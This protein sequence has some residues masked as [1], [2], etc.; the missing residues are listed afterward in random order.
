M[1]KKTI[2]LALCFAMLISMLAAG[3]TTT[4]AAT[5]ESAPTGYSRIESADDFSWDNANVYFLL[6]DRFANGDTSNDHSYGRAL[7]ANGSPLSGWQTAPGT[8][9]GGDFKGLT[10]KINEGYFDDLGVNAIWLSA[11]YEQIHGYVDSGDGH[12]AHYSYHGYYVLDYTE[13]DKN[14]GT[15]AEFKTLVDTAHAHGIRVV[16]DIV[17]NHAGYNNIVDMEEFN[18][19]TITDKSA[20][21]AYKY[22]LTGVDGFHSFIDYESSASDWGRWWGNDW[23]RSGLPGYTGGNGGDDITRCLAGLPD[24]RTEST[25]SVSVPTFLQTK[26]QKEGTLSAKQSKYSGCTTVSDY[27]TTWLSEWVE[28][29]GVDGFR[30]DTAKHV[31]LASWKKLKT[32]CVTALQN[33]RRNNPTA[34]GAD[35]DEDFWMTGECWDYG[36]GKSEYHTV[37][38]FDSMINFSYSGRSLDGP[39]SIN[40]VYQD[41]ADRINSDPNFNVLTYNS[42]HDS[43]LA[44]GDLYW[45]GTSLML[46]PG[47]VQPFYGDETNRPTVPGMS[48]DGHGGSGHSLRS[49]MNWDS[50]DTD[51]LAHWQKVGKFRN[52]HVAVGAG[53]HRLISAYNGSTGYTFARTYDDGDVSDAVVCCIGAPANQNITVNLGSTFASGKTVTNEYDGTTA[54]VTNG[55]ATFNSGPQGV[56][57]ISGPQ[58]TINMSLKSEKR[59]FYD[60]MTVTVSLRGADYAMV[61]VA[62]G[63]PFRVVDGQSFEI[64][65]GIEVG[66]SFDVTMTATN[67]V[68]TSEMTFSYKKKDPSAVTYVYF[69]N[70]QYN[71]SNVN[72]YVYKGDGDSASSIKAWPGEAMEFDSTTGLYVYEVDED[73]AD[74]GAVVFNA[75]SG[76]A[77]YPAEGV[78]LEI[79]GTDKILINKTTWKEYENE[80]VTP[81]DPPEPG[82]MRTIYFDNS[83]DKFAVPSCHAWK[84]DGSGDIPYQTW[85]G[86]AMTSLGNNLYKCEVPAEYNCCL[87]VDRNNTEAKTTDLRD[88]PYLNAKYSGGSWTEV[89]GDETQPTDPT[90]PTNPT[91]PTQPTDPTEPDTGDKVLLGDANLDGNITIKDVTQIQRHCAELIALSGDNYTAADVDKSGKVAIKDATYVQMFLAEMDN[92]AYVNTYV[93]KGGNEPT[94]PTTPTNP[95]EPTT[96]SEDPAGTRTIYLDVTGYNTTTP[97]VYVWKKGSQD[98]VAAFPGEAMT[99]VSGSIYSYTCQADYNCCIFS[100]DGGGN[101]KITGDLEDIPYTKALYHDGWTQYDG[102]TP[103]NPTNPPSGDTVTL[104][105]GTFVAGDEDWYAWTW[106]GDS[107][108]KWLS[109]TGTATAY[110]FTGDIGDHIL[111]VRVPKG[112]QP[113]WNPRN[114]YNQTSNLNT[115]IGGTYVITSWYNGNWQ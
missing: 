77:Q 10:Q 58:S 50:I 73:F 70:T 33:W 75:G 41:Y 62:G 25:A 85:P 2:S 38:G 113:S 37:G 79:G 4:S 8:F 9:H 65:E 108:G 83:V 81:P 98:S 59:A 36:S 3:F 89:Q 1:K 63:T 84:N 91:D 102:T 109:G 55:C 18:Y 22:K 7:D 69:D 43:N 19:G 105:N 94:Q 40:N 66:A 44:R 48:F 68:E 110:V 51:V 96:P 101:S 86:V 27:L 35:W 112:E 31:E 72:I 107:E 16:M 6:T 56:I 115:Q 88:I 54:V 32:K 14:F 103:S 104:N 12:F 74:E 106:N 64:G 15:K 82:T 28:T 95:T 76:Q 111:F 100:R 42:S 34:V 5:V 93:N 24:F 52:N 20:I 71:W 57:L 13:T 97:Y 80:T 46:L 11:P 114:I 49:D 45:Q 87:F 30:C 39:S 29:Y 17:M 23:V 90:D 61:S 99:L 78:R 53:D 60:S 67:A 21:D 92:H 26:W 47:G